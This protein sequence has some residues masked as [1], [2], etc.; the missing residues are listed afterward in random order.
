MLQG[1]TG[2]NSD[3]SSCNLA[4]SLV[5]MG[6]E[7]ASRSSVSGVLDVLDGGSDWTDVSSESLS[8]SDAGA[9][10]SVAVEE[11]SSAAGMIVGFLVGC[12]VVDPRL[13]LGCA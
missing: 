11:S 8:E 2:G 4:E 12:L 10:F 6:L 9:V 1:R 13:A 3:V 5:D 7:V